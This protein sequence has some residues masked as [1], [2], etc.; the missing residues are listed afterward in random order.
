MKVLDSYNRPINSVRISVTNR[1]NLKCFY[2]HMEGLENVNQEMTVDEIARVVRVLARVGIKKVKITGGEP[3][4]RAD[5]VDIVRAIS[6]V[7]GIEEVSITTNGT[8]LAGLT[9][10]LKKAGL[11]RVNVNLPSLKNN[12]YSWITG[13]RLEKGVLTVLEGVKEAVEAGLKPVKVNMV[14][15]KGVNEGEIPD[16]IELSRKSGVI[17][18]LI[19]LETNNEKNPFYEKF[20]ADLSWVEKELRR[21]AVKVVK[22]RLH[23][24]ERFY[25]EN[26]AVV[27]VVRPMHNTRFC[28]NCTRIRVTHN[29]KFK[30]CLMRCD[31]HVDFLYALRAGCRDE[32]L[33]SL[34]VR[35]V[36]Y[37]E[38]YFKR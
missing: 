35:A 6:S 36:S 20:H 4:V 30:P 3:L 19:E 38:P 14:V 33:L 23:N 32:D 17:V 7:E 34:F 18:Q 12:V 25:L 31:N 28:E 5:I 15:L 8:L 22:R 26:G 1:C 24:R 11:K 9:S 13:V 27:E 10:Q 29:G 16:F 21:K 2:C 37:R